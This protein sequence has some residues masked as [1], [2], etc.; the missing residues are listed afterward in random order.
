MVEKRFRLRVLGVAARGEKEAVTG[1]VGVESKGVVMQ[2]LNAGMEDEVLT[3]SVGVL[4]DRPC[5]RRGR[6][7]VAKAGGGAKARGKGGTLETTVSSKSVGEPLSSKDCSAQSLRASACVEVRRESQTAFSA[8]PQA[9]TS[10][11]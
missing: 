9:P 5:F 2:S 10:K 3:L 11:W 4:L 6:V 1:E 7:V 8:G